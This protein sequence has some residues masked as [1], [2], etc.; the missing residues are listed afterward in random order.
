MWDVLI[1]TVAQTYALVE[2]SLPGVR[3][4]GVGACHVLRLPLLQGS[5]RSTYRVFHK[6]D[7]HD[8][9]IATPD[10]NHEMS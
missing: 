6:T 3:L 10:A 9:E 8:I 5:Y 7:E 2:V 4:C 1:F